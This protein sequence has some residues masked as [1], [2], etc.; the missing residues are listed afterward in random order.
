L[1]WSLVEYVLHRFI[2]HMDARTRKQRLRAF[3][4][5]G[6]HHEYPNDKLR[7]VA[8]PLMSWP[9]G[10]VLAA[11]SRWL[12]GSDNWLPFYAGI[13]IGYLAYDYVH[14]YSHHFRPKRGLGKWLRAYHMLHHY[15]SRESRFGVSSPLWDFVFGTYQPVRRDDAAGGKSRPHARQA[16]HTQSD[17]PC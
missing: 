5:H 10:L 1:V 8:P 2:F 15:E 7:L 14:Y 17:G 12:L 9:I 6:Y 16:S 11:M 3:L 4:M 13:A